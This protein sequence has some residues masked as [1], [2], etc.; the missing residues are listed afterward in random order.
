MIKTDN[1]V[2]AIIDDGGVYSEDRWRTYTKWWMMM[3]DR[4][5]LMNDV[6]RGMK[7]T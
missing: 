6:E 1:S 4:N 7:E 2:W 5:I 3:N